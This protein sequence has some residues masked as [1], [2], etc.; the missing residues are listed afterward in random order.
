MADIPPGLDIRTLEIPATFVN[1]A[2]VARLGQI[3]VR[4]TFGESA[5]PN[6]VMH[7]AAVVMTIDDARSLANVLQ[8]A[9]ASNIVQQPA[10]SRPN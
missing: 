3:L 7:R 5:S 10:S 1:H 8:K 9:L 6:A 4:I 2:Q